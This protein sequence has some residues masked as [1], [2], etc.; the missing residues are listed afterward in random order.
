MH[1]AAER[2]NAALLRQF[3]HIAETVNVGDKQGQTPL[4]ACTSN[5]GDR[6]RRRL[7]EEKLE[8]MAVLIEYSAI[9]DARD[10]AGYTALHYASDNGNVP[11]VNM[12]LENGCRIHEPG[13]VCFPP[14]VLC[15]VYYQC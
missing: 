12:L 3:A 1:V 9:L 13:P 15:T 2:G 14:T 7:T 4:H 10:H 6:G 8:C 11:V 5:I